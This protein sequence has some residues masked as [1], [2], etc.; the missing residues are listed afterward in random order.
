VYDNEESVSPFARPLFTQ[1]FSLKN[2]V[3]LSMERKIQSCT[4]LLGLRGSYLGEQKAM[5]CEV[6]KAIEKLGL[7]PATHGLWMCADAKSPRLAFQRTQI[8]IHHFYQAASAIFQ[9]KWHHAGHRLWQRAQY[10]TLGL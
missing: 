4:T 6:C 7:D 9:T 5:K 8:K 10:V 3:L 2:F 1:V